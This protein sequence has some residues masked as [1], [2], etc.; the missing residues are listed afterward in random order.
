MSANLTIIDGKLTRIPYPLVDFGDTHEDDEIILFKNAGYHRTIFINP[1]ALDYVSLPT[2]K[3][4]AGSLEMAA[5]TLDALGDDPTPTVTP[6]TKK[7]R[8]TKAAEN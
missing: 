1:L 4:E 5:E 7:K 6:K 2:H 3:F 8:Q